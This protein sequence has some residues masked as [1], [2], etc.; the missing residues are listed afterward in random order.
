MYVSNV[1]VGA[2]REDVSLNADV[3][4]TLCYDATGVSYLIVAFRYHATRRINP[5]LTICP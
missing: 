1:T 2:G 3:S 5:G 4:P